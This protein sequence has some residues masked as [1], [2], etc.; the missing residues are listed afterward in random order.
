MKNKKDFFIITSEEMQNLPPNV[1]Q[2]DPDFPN[3]WWKSD[4]FYWEKAYDL[5]YEY[6][7][8]VAS[9]YDPTVFHSEIV[10]QPHSGEDY[11]EL[12]FKLILDY[13][14]AHNPD[15]LTDTSPYPSERVMLPLSSVAQ[16][17]YVN[18]YAYAFRKT[19]SET[20]GTL[21][22]YG[23]TTACTGDNN[24]EVTIAIPVGGGKS[25]KLAIRFN[26]ALLSNTIVGFNLQG[27]E[28]A[29]EGVSIKFRGFA[30]KRFPKK[31]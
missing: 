18:E 23:F 2:P 25:K 16:G 27:I 26:E 4:T 13:E 21:A 15:E 14:F 1:P 29:I 11:I 3:Y 5:N 22:I 9:M 28:E 17:G 31:A 8:E 6:K 20:K 24:A 10:I 7:G 12:W 19:I 30:Y